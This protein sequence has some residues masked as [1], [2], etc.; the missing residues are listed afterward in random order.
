[1]MRAV[2]W[3]T[4]ALALI[5][6]IIGLFVPGLPT[7][8]LVLL[9]AACWSKASPRLHNWLLTHKRFGPMVRNWEE[10]R[11]IPLKAKI[12]SSTMMACSCAW[13]LWAYPERLWTGILT[14]TVCI[15]TAIWIWRLP[16]A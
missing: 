1:M 10:R 2:L 14:L 13:L 12:L 8:P 16:N 5:I 7:T 15:C 6:G 4:G 9:A 11:A 3:L